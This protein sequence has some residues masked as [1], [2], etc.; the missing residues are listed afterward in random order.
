MQNSILVIFVLEIYKGVWTSK[1]SSKGKYRPNKLE[2]DKPDNNND[3][4]AQVYKQSNDKHAR[5][6]HANYKPTNNLTQ[7]PTKLQNILVLDACDGTYESMFG[8]TAYNQTTKT[9][10]KQA[11]N[12]QALR[13][14]HNS[15]Y[16]QTKLMVEIVK[17]YF[18]H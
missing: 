1:I 2:N 16:F 7:K 12:V 14:Y 11:I 4:Q 3:K 18:L 5:S 10:H 6:K 8:S 15:F 9:R 17:N 13:N